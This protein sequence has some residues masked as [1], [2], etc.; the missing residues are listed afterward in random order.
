MKDSDLV[1]VLLIC[2]FAAIIGASVCG[3]WYESNKITTPNNQIITTSTNLDNLKADCY[4]QGFV[5]GR[6]S[7]IEEESLTGHKFDRLWVPEGYN[8]TRTKEWRE[9]ADYIAGYTT[10]AP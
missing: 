1:A 9:Y 8:S 6:A 4:T 10:V 2:G 3:L 5:D 7:R